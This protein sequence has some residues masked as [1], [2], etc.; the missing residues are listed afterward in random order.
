MVVRGLVGLCFALPF[1]VVSFGW[2]AAGEKPAAPG[3]SQLDCKLC[4]APFYDSWALSAHG[5][6]T[7]DPAFREQWEAEGRPTSCLSCHT[8]GF[9]PAT[10]L[11]EAEGILC[12]A[13]HGP[14]PEKH[15]KDPMPTDRSARFCGTCHM[16]TH[17]EWQV[18]KHRQ[19]ELACV[20]CHDP[21]GTTLL[22]ENAS[23]LCANCHRERASNFA[24]SAHA[25]QDLDCADCHLGPTDSQLGEGH[26][27]RDHSF[28]VR[29]STCNECHSYQMHDPVQVH[30]EP[31][32]TPATAE[33]LASAEGL[34]LMAEPPGR[35][36]IGFAAVAGLVGMATGM[37]LAPWLERWYG[38]LREE[39]V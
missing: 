30:P 13:C 5:L 19:V 35:S 14:Y 39:D 16:E 37:I 33:P 36:L 27:L 15:P 8:T 11:W 22:A 4:H 25:E 38:R 7:V 26:A 28:N 18:S 29:L 31:E 23:A 12:S 3:G 9:D 2:A 17:F 32:A 6:A 24:H 21:H 34:L 1:M 10:G 20:G